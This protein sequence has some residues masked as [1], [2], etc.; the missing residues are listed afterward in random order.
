MLGFV[1]FQS[2][3]LL[4]PVSIP[5]VPNKTN[6]IQIVDATLAEC[7]PLLTLN[8]NPMLESRILP[9]RYSGWVNAEGIWRSRWPAIQ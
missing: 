6:F 2:L 9:R 7:L 1:M 4:I 5:W 3:E 8:A